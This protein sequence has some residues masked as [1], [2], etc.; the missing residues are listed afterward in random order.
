MAIGVRI[1]EARRMAG[2]SQEKLGAQAKVTKQAISKYERDKATPSSRVLLRLAEALAVP[3]DFFFR[4]PTVGA[5]HALHYRR[6]ARLAAKERK[7]IEASAR[8]W[9]ERY[10]E[11]EAFL[12]SEQRTAFSVP[13]EVDRRVRSV[14][15]TERLAE[16]LR[17]AWRLGLN[18]IDNLMEV[19][20]Q[21]GLKIFL[22]RT[23]RH[24]DGLTLVADGEFHVIVVRQ[25]I[26]GDRQR[27]NLAHELGHLVMELDGC[28]DGE[29]AAYRFAGAFVVPRAQAI[30]ELGEHRKSI[31]LTELGALKSRY[32]LS[33]Q[34]WIYRARDL[35]I[36]SES[37]AT[38]LFREFRRK[39]WRER[40]PGAQL[41]PEKPTR[42]A[43]LAAKAVVE[44]A[45]S[46]SRAAELLG[47][48][49]EEFRKESHQ[50]GEASEVGACS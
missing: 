35:N 31:S 44:E 17:N 50:L 6:H 1:K 32:G 38:R 10:L 34:A 43:R 9:L 25:E 40:E 28:V 11:L 29:R 2:L 5:V 8:E 33:M 12:P 27:L 49:L 37:A 13:P 20:E 36:L 48:H 42:M 24:F 18:P 15:D 3:I 45:V 39:G 46:E 26:S 7:S 4:T 30:L 19:L 22:L 16:E 14:E 47:E 21:R 23:S 41:A